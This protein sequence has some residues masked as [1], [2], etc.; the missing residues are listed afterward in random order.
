M[1]KYLLIIILFIIIIYQFN[2]LNIKHKTEYF[3]DAESAV[4]DSLPKKELFEIFNILDY[5]NTDKELKINDLYV[6]NICSVENCESKEGLVTKLGTFN[7]KV[8]ISPE[9]ADKYSLQIIRDGNSGGYLFN[10]DILSFKTKDANGADDVKFSID[11]NKND[12]QLENA[13]LTGEKMYSKKYLNLANSLMIAN[14]QKSAI[15][16]RRVCV[17]WPTHEKITCNGE[18]TFCDVLPPTQIT[19]KNHPNLG[20]YVAIKHLCKGDQ[21]AHWKSTRGSGNNRC[22]GGRAPNPVFGAWDI[23]IMALNTI[24]KK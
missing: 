23:N 22:T 8:D 4:L 13:N 7:G 11:P 3:T 15:N 21:Y 17:H 16:C 2:G 20:N 14:L 19:E 9:S 5:H 24:P 1:W 12:V 6:N 18:D 10:G